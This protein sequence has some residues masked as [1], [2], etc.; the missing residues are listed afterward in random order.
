[1]A[2]Q[3]YVSDLQGHILY[4]MLVDDSK[5]Q[6]AA[7]IAVLEFCVLRALTEH[8]VRI[9]SDSVCLFMYCFIVYE[10]GLAW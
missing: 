4:K 6:F 7:S 8:R 9:F 2:Q 5:A 1:M 3:V 10:L